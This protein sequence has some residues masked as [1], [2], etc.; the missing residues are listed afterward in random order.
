MQECIKNRMNLFVSVTSDLCNTQ[1][2]RKLR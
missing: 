2:H 1:K